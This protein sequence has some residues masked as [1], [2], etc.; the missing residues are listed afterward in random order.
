MQ[1][2]VCGASSTPS[3]VQIG[4]AAGAI[5]RG[6]RTRAQAALRPASDPERFDAIVAFDNAEENKL[7]AVSQ[8]RQDL[9]R[10]K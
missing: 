3:I 2:R 7:Q 5:C 8:L 4:S 6:P 1:L 9:A 10:K